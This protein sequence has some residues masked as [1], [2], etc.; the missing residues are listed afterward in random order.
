MFGQNVGSL[1]LYMETATNPVKSNKLW[2]RNGNQGDQ[3]VQTAYALTSTDD[4]WIVFEGVV[5]ADY[6]SD[7]AVDDIQIVTGACPSITPPTN[8]FDCGDGTVVTIQ[9]VCDFNPDCANGKDE[10]S[11]GNCT[12]EAAQGGLCGWKDKSSGSFKWTNGQGGTATSNTGPNTD[13]TLGTAAGSYMFVDAN[14]GRM[15]SLAILRS[16]KLRQSSATCQMNFWY[17]MFGR[18]IGSLTVAMKTG[19]RDVRLWT[20]RGSQGNRWQQGTVFIGRV[21]RPFRMLIEAQRSFSVFGDIAIDD[22]TFVN[23]ALPKARKCLN[24]EF[25]CSN[26]VCIDK[27]R[28]C[29]YEDDCG[30]GSDEDLK[31]LC[32]Y[33]TKCSFEKSFC[34]F[35]QDTT[36]DFNWSRAQGILPSGTSGATGPSR[37]HTTGLDTG[38]YT[39]IE[40]SS[41]RKPGEKARLLSR[42]FDTMTA[43][44]KCYMTFYYHMLGRDM[45]TLT[46]YTRT[47]IGGYFTKV[48][49]KTGNTNKDVWVRAS[50]LLTSSKPFQVVFEG[51]R[52][53]GWASDMAL[54]D[55]AFG[56][57][58]KRFS[59]NLPQAGQTTQGV[60][61]T[62]KSPSGT[63][64]SDQFQCANGPCI[65]LKWKCDFSKDCTDGSDEL[66]CGPCDF[67]K[68]QCGW[69]DNSIGRY[70]WTRNKGAT[71]SVRTG[72]RTDHTLKTDQGYY[73]YVEGGRGE[74]LT[75][76]TLVSPALPAAAKDCEMSFFYHMYGNR[77]GSLIASVNVN[78]T[79]TPVYTKSGNQGNRWVQGTVYIGQ[80]M[81]ALSQGFTVDFKV[82]PGRNF[83]SA[84]RS[85]DI[86]I[87][88]IT[89]N[90]CNPRQAAPNL[91]CDF[92]KDLCAW[93]Q[94][95]NSVDDVFDW[96]RTK[97]STASS[98]TG[99]RFDHTKGNINGY[100]VY[101]ETSQPRKQGDTAK[102]ESN[103]LPPTPPT[104][105]CLSFWYHMFGP[106][107]N[108]L[109]VIME[110]AQTRRVIWR[111]SRSQG[112]VWKQAYRSIK[113]DKNYRIAIQGTSG[114]SYRGDIAVDDIKVLNGPCPPPVLCDFESGFCGWKQPKTDDFDWTR[115]R[116]GTASIGTGAPF[117]H[118][119]GTQS[120]Y[121][122]YIETSR[123]RK[124]GDQAYLVSPRYD[125]SATRCLQFWYHMSGRTI[126]QLSVYQPR[127]GSNMFGAPIWF[128]NGDQDNIWR[129]AKITLPARSPGYNVIFVGQ[130]GAGYQGDIAID[131]VK[132]TD[133][134]CPISGF[135]N[136]ETDM[137]GWTNAINGVNDDFDWLRDNGGTPSRFTGPRVDHTTGSDQGYYVYIET[138]GSFRK[139]GEIAQLVSEHL[140]PTS[141]KCLSFWY[142][143]Y[144]AGVG[145]LTVYT[146][147]GKQQP[148]AAWSLGGNQNNIWRLASVNLVASAE[149]T[150]MIEATHGGNYTG[151]I[152]IDDI[153][154]LSRSCATTTPTPSTTA[155]TVP[156]STPRP[157]MKCT[158]DDAKAPFCFWQQETADQFDWTRIQGATASPGTGPQADHTSLSS[159]GYY[160]Y[161]ETSGR[162][163]N[164]TARLSSLEVD[165][166]QKGTCVEFWYHMYGANIYKLNVLTQ[167]TDSSKKEEKI[168]TKQ[169]NQGGKWKYAQIHLQKVGRYK[170]MFEGIVGSRWD[171]DIALD[172]ITFAP[173]GCPASKVCDFENGMCNFTQDVT[174]IF[175]WTLSNGGTPST[176]TG[177]R[178]DHTYGTQAGYYMYIETSAPRKFGDSARLDSPMYK[179]TTGACLTFWYHMRG[180]GIGTLNVYR[181]ERGQLGSKI[182]TL[183]GDE[184]NEWHVWQSNIQSA[185]PYQITFEGIRG[186]TYAGDIAIDDVS[187]VDGKRCPSFGSCDFEEDT[188]TWKNIA[189]G[190]DFDWESGTGATL[191]AGTGP[192]V[193]HTLNTT[194]GSY[195]YIEASSPRKQGDKAW[196]VSQVFRNGSNACLQFYYHMKGSTIG[197]L[198]IM[199]WPY[200]AGATQQELWKVSGNQGD[201]WKYGQ[202]QFG[203]NVANYRLVIEGSIGSSYQGDIAIDDLIVSAGTCPPG[204]TQPPVCAYQCSDGKCVPPKKVCDFNRDCSDG[205]DEIDCGYDCTFENNH[206]CKWNDTSRGSFKWTKYR[207][208]TPDSNTGPSFDHTTLSPNGYYLYVDASRGRRFALASL[209]SPTLQQSA[210]TCQ[211]TFWYHM[212]GKNIGTL[213]VFHQEGARVTEMYYI[214]GNQGNKWLQAKIPIGRLRTPFNILIR[215]QRTFTVLGDI[216]IDDISFQGCSLP[217]PSPNG[218]CNRR[219][220][221]CSTGA[222]ID[223]WRRC[224]FTD[225][226]GDGSDETVKQ[227]QGYDKCSFEK[228]LC[229]WRQE[230]D[231]QF[232]FIRRSGATGSFRTG[233]T[234]DH[235][236]NTAAGYYIYIET[237]APRKKGDKARIAYNKWLQLS[238][239]RFCAMRFYYHMYG[240]H[241]DTLTV[242]TRTQ[243]NGQ[244]TRV[245][246]RKGAVGNYFERGNVI[247]PRRS[248]VVQVVIEAS[249]GTSYRGDIALDDISFSPGCQQY[250]GTIPTAA[251]TLSTAPPTV[252][253]CGAGKWQCKNSVCID[254]TKKCNFVSDCS[255]GSD[256][257]DCGAC[258]FENG[259][260]G[261]NDISTSRYAWQ[262]YQGS[263]PHTLSGPN[264]DHTKGTAQGWY[265]FVDSLQGT[266]VRNAILQSPVYGSTAAGCEMTF[267]I[268]KTGDPRGLMRLY[269]LPNGTSTTGRIRLWQQFGD[270]G[271]NW[272]KI[273]IGINRRPAGF[274]LQLFG[275]H[276][277]RSGDMAIDDVTFNNCALGSTTAGPCTTSQ[278]KCNNGKCIDKK[279][280]CDFS[281]DCGDKSDEGTQCSAYVERCNFENDF[282]NW[283]Q[284][285]SDN[286]DWT[287]K[288]GATQSVNTGPSRDHTLGTLA[289]TY[290]YIETSSPRKP[291]DAARIYS[292]NFLA[293]TSGQC[294]MR[295]FSHMYGAH[296]NALNVYTRSQIGGQLNKIWSK[297]NSS[298]DEWVRQEV[299]LKSSVPFQVV[300]EGIRGVSYAGDIGIDDISFTPFCAVTGV[301]LAPAT[302]TPTA[303]GVGKMACRDGTCRDAADF[304]NFRYDCR[305]SSDEMTCPQTCQFEDTTS[306]MCYWTNSKSDDF[307]WIIGS[308]G[309][310]S[311]GTGPR[312][313]HT[314]NSI[315]GKYA[316]LESSGKRF[317][318]K[319]R[320]VSPIYRQAGSTCSFSFYYH[321]F[322]RNTG[323]LNV[324]ISKGGTEIPLWSHNGNLG[325]KWNQAM[326][327]LPTCSSQFQMIIEGTVGNGWQ[328]DIAIDDLRFDNCE[329][330][331]PLVTPCQSNQFRC[332]SGHCVSNNVKCDFQ[333]DCCDGSDET[334][335]TCSPNAY[336]RCNFERN[337]DLCG[338][339]QMSDDQF[340]WS[341]QQ[342][343]TFSV[344]TGPGFD[345]TTQGRTGRYL[346]IEASAPRKAGDKARLG[347]VLNSATAAQ[348]SLRF[349]YHMFGSHIGSL[350]VYSRTAVNGQ[351]KTLLTLSGSQGDAWRRAEIPLSSSTPIQILIEGLIGPGWQGDIALDDISFTPGCT[352]G[353]TIQTVSPV[354]T[355]PTTPGGQLNQCNSAQFRCSDGTCI[356]K[357]KVCDFMND[358][359]DRSDEAGCRDTCSFETDQCGWAENPATANDNFDWARGTG[360][361]TSRN[362]A[363]PSDATYKNGNGYFM[364]I[365]DSTGGNP[366]QSKAELV[367][368]T[369]NLAMSTCTVEFYYYKYGSRTGDLELVLR[370]PS[371][372]SGTDTSLFRTYYQESQDSW[373]SVTIGLGRR[374]VPFN[375]V[376]RKSG[377]VY[378]GAIAIDEI[379]FRGCSIPSASPSCPRSKFSCTKT[380]ACIEYNKVCD[381]QD[382]CGDNSDEDPSV[383]NQYKR[384]D[385]E[386]GFQD[387]SQV[388]NGDDNFDWSRIKGATPSYYSGPSRDHTKGDSTGYFL[389]IE[390]SSPQ[391][392]GMKAWLASKVFAPTNS[393]Q[394]CTMRMFYHMYGRHVNTLSVYKRFTSNGSPAGQA[395]WTK[396]GS[397]GDYWQKVEI[398]LQGITQPFV[399]LIEAT[400]GDDYQGDI[401]IDDISFTTDCQYSSVT[402][403][404]ASPNITPSQSTITT[405]PHS[406]D[407]TTQANCY[408][409]QCIKKSQVCDFRT[410]CSDGSDAS[411]CGK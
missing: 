261:W 189:T 146:Q 112:N 156:G 148:V 272:K 28:M 199:Q 47:E 32:R 394:Q 353:S 373:K 54:D 364:F 291:N 48:W 98:F 382:D 63:C 393:G 177:P 311:Q 342:G 149:F 46:V 303:C 302:P 19:T 154:V 85:D 246:Q 79:S 220:F 363:P 304:C 236:T 96:T 207:G 365:R 216:A 65:D 95:I 244:L 202:V 217:T 384:F 305:D 77:V 70:D 129:R 51:I 380:K 282:C 145:N 410:D 88:D 337:G 211:V 187:V 387:F 181:N 315:T 243:V 84:S 395:L 82:G 292:R 196:L 323:S 193:D 64:R 122:A 338:W 49:S 140:Q 340:D 59:Q 151:D 269:L 359:Q 397:Q 67:E 56:A 276:I 155:V 354:I 133:G 139:Q 369:Y 327:F 179:P 307:D 83:G 247:F 274:S 258:D 229:N 4:F 31:K 357:A 367:S 242:Y 147:V 142:H 325:D 299:V 398:S 347:Y 109:S 71:P 198:R 128:R 200:I 23:C 264:V 173:G 165:I 260:C 356:D 116:N 178:F 298:K 319:A 223:Q 392:Y 257:A 225:D 159:S 162:Q 185:L 290:I 138:S 221:K 164:D 403:P 219:Q 204:P 183:S 36:D 190:D 167:T 252:N 135:C 318:Q 377:Y 226:C 24:T 306:P 11:C 334:L 275:T 119:T 153:R 168:W 284:D 409:G 404:T 113:S 68:D 297:Q 127:A 256:E 166:D 91:N 265:M 80:K 262:R 295:F 176:F 62:T 66:G 103:V 16:M 368:P 14:N 92:E 396:A 195:M 5:G 106:D 389:Y 385:F 331:K 52:G 296:I 329:Y 158:F 237:S 336:Q 75:K 184:G 407:L 267:W 105:H 248:Q 231:D 41:P 114:P 228:S 163:P 197:Q 206:A 124:Q 251:T 390:T 212:Y 152:A 308:G 42:N 111:R 253:P 1:R 125:S 126:G 402:L 283:Q 411:K 249:R 324:Y 55:I 203:T 201:Q 118:T 309:T 240:D 30:D 170:V 255:D 57:G 250:T 50:V 254:V 60:T 6:R 333:T 271:K 40:A 341:Q 383:C 224:D 174:D 29:D 172:D 188:C 232:D 233:P 86:A 400:V 134:R 379:R 405:A 210:A 339:M 285:T 131:D 214:Q 273:T 102:L 335:Q 213:R 93:N 326:V 352:R 130:R 287:R 192:G 259:Q 22:V 408:D 161:I 61:S 277:L 53:K 72:P 13:H 99:P 58:C 372:S 391:S 45:G 141:A 289:G 241:I 346:F 366:G 263:T 235:T 227:C 136:F 222:C 115:G 144:G 361:S 270:L 208:A 9:K 294:V 26:G 399:I 76:A 344:N 97:G 313:D 43:N 107:V 37:D 388:S 317:N 38:F 374:R 406:C 117:D 90:N 312:F 245:W 73:M 300:I 234:R 17:H 101:I 280:Q 349:W 320:F 350:N 94:G 230:K 20:R 268:H 35:K 281:D 121:F 143:M 345:H 27:N 218:Q 355:T 286:F 7:M 239:T 3:W 322:G 21:S 401:A 157:F 171:G 160:I 378:D 362:E 194:F 120:G 81:G 78:G 330:P 278:F 10:Q 108:S 371:K 191:S 15:N 25:Q 180:F 104:G 182:F 150:V 358:C 332:N 376:L 328:G 316:Y 8:S 381:L 293:T 69:N 301:T 288:T 238:S 186:T 375:L 360:S 321:M 74:F 18:S 12:F 89:F 175:D 215:A 169:G 266:F 279:L 87:D 205:G 351:M 33:R 110:T 343:S 123:P 310:P 386:V 39:Y 132:V 2:E 100:Y 370:E 209:K 348:C 34:S 314:R 44:D 137:C